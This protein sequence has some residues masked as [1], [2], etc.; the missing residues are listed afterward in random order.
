MQDIIDLLKSG[1]AWFK[2]I[3][4][5]VFEDTLA[6]IAAVIFLIFFFF[7]LKRM[8]NILQSFLDVFVDLSLRLLVL[9]IVVVILY[10]IFDSTR[11]CSLPMEHAI[12]RCDETRTAR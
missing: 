8:L 12:T 5:S 10:I 6:L 11:P 4:D 1:L 9:F 3:I 7:F 2:E